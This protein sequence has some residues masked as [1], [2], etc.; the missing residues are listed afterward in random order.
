MSPDIELSL[1]RI[2]QEA[3]TNVT[4]HAQARQARVALRKRRGVL[5]L[6]VE[7]DGRGFVLP[8]EP[9]ELSGAGDPGEA[10]VAPY[11][12][13]SLSRPALVIYRSSGRTAPVG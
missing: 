12:A 4:R 3:L 5:R 11:A 1:Y 7:D 10:P 13:C 8:A 6:V 9:A 2:V